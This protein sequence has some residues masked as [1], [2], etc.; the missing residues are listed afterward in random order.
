MNDRADEVWSTITTLV[1]DSRG[2]YRRA[3]IAEVGM[4]FSRVRALRRLVE[5]P[6]TMKALAEAATMDASAATVS[7]NDLEQRGLVTRE[8]SS[9]SGR[10]KVVTI[11]AA[12]RAVI[13]RVLAIR[14]PAPAAL[15]ALSDDKLAELQ[16]LLR[17]PR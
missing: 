3:V 17:P 10:E 11:T 1:T 5:S 14:Q 6:L 12:G 8:A 9:T 4:P 13:D 15:A 16:R 2:D 7:V